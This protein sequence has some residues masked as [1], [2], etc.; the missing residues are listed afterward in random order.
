N[1]ALSWINPNPVGTWEV[2][3]TSTFGSSWGVPPSRP[4]APMGTPEAASVIDKAGNEIAQVTVYRAVMDHLSGASIM[5]PSAEAGWHAIVVDGLPP[6]VYGSN[7][8]S[9][10]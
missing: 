7:L 5:V 3:V 4:V 8:A 10:P 2:I 6:M 1:G 9:A